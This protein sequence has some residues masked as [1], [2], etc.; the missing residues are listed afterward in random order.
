MEKSSTFL[1]LPVLSLQI[2]LHFTLTLGNIDGEKSKEGEVGEALV[3]CFEGFF[4]CLFFNSLSFLVKMR[5]EVY[6]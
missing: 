6:L 2:H 1:T 3:I 5:K 4:V